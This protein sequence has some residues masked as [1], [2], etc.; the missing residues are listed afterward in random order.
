[1]YDATL[2]DLC[3]GIDPTDNDSCNAASNDRM[4]KEDCEATLRCAGG[5]VGGML[6]ED[7]CLAD[8]GTWGA[9]RCQ[10]GVQA[11][12]AV[13][14][15]VEPS[16]ANDANAQ[17]CG[18]NVDDPDASRGS[19]NLDYIPSVTDSS[20]KCICDECYMT[21]TDYTNRNSLGG[22]REYCGL[23]VC[24]AEGVAQ[25]GPSQGTE[26]VISSDTAGRSDC[27]DNPSCK[28]FAEFAELTG[29]SKEILMAFGAVCVL[30]VLYCLINIACDKGD[31]KEYDSDHEDSSDDND[32]EEGRD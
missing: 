20:M 3:Q 17:L 14:R 6:D 32:D 12:Y 22:Y 21:Q 28:T 23:N 1:M 16:P 10:T 4:L 24:D 27:D 11:K 25:W 9:K 15:Y 13:W 2:D 7:A 30:L 29:A 5:T 31:S 26:I 19:I 18:Y 8:G